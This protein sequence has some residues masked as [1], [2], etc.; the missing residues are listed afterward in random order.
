[1]GGSLAGR[2]GGIRRVN[3]GKIHGIS[4]LHTRKKLSKSNLKRKKI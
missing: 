2:G 3:G 1:V 4:A